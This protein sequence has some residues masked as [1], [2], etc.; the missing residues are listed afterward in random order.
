M[1]LHKTV[2]FICRSAVRHMWLWL[3]LTLIPTIP[4]LYAIG[5]LGLNTDIVRLL[6]EHSRA[7]QWT[8]KLE[9]VVGDGGFFTILL[10]DDN[11]EALVKAVEAT[12]AEVEK[13]TTVDSVSYT[14]PKSFI[15]TYRYLLITTPY[16]E[17]I[18]D[19]IL[20][21]KAEISP[22][23]NDL[24]SSETT[25]KS[26]QSRRE[27]EEIN[28]L[29]N[30]Y[31]NLSR[32]HESVDGTTMGIFIRPQPGSTRI[33]DLYGLL[34]ELE[35]ISSETA[36]RYEVWTGVGG[37]QIY[38]L[39]EYEVIIDDLVRSGRITLIAILLVLIVSFRS[40][41]VLPVLL[42]PLAAGLL[43][44][45][46]LVPPL[47]GDLNIISSFL[48]VVLFGLGIDF[49][50]HLVKRFQLELARKR[51]LEALCATYHST[52]MSVMTS[53]LTTGLALL[54][55][56]F[57]DFRGFAEFGIIGGGT[58]LI[59]LFAMFTVMP[60]TLIAGERY[61]LVKPISKEIQTMV[62]ISPWVLRGCL[63]L[64]PL[65][66][67]A[68]V[69]N[70]RFDF[71]F[72]AQKPRV[73]DDSLFTTYNKEVY[74]T[75]YLS[76]GAIFL[77]PDLVS[78]DGLLA[79][80]DGRMHQPETTFLKTTSIRSFAPDIKEGQTRLELIADIQDALQGSW[81]AKLKDPL[82]QRWAEDFRDWVPPAALPTVADLPE[83]LTASLKTGGEADFYLVGLYPNVSRGNGRNA[84]AFAQEMYDLQIPETIAGPVGE[85]PVF[86]EILWTVTAEGP[87][88]VIFSFASVFLL[89][90]IGF[91]SLK[92]TL[93]VSLPLVSG[94][95]FTM[96]LMAV[97]GFKLNFFNVVVF[98]ALI[99][100]G[101]DAGVH[102]YRRWQEMDGDTASCCGE[103]FAPLSVCTLTSMMGYSGMA[104]ASHPGL[105]SIGLLA[106]LGLGCIWF[107]S[108][109]F[110][111][112]VLNWLKNRNKID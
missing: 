45:F 53:A 35:R 31:F 25:G 67:M 86:A 4:A 77:A 74:R 61:G 24:M 34:G 75:R 56:G 2:E 9:T 51:P 70:F 50:I 71:D 95:V 96:G 57:S 110:F 29:L 32:Y 81:T 84:M 68:A 46:A 90:F 44:A 63:L 102:F 12:A 54:V 49:S 109:F 72:N 89:I 16:L 41:A 98:P 60:A 40:V 37:S 10:H 97:S 64:L 103:L 14:H 73:Q 92:T 59:I 79:A 82:L 99:G 111:P 39:R 85:M 27:M 83:S 48:L 1:F 15:E 93:W 26:Q 11:R 87:W 17:K 19:H 7:A 28:R 62:K 21:Q 58:V 100:M 18:F 13:L 112:G 43:W 108:L 106:C 3:L 23:T 78:L 6:P 22:F 66:I 5:D 55:L 94:L 91:R 88:V 47:L 38:N 107:T 36:E 33:K 42:C 80:L 105:R 8:K 76:P 104:F 20:A 69:I 65:C 101:V 30:H 52:G